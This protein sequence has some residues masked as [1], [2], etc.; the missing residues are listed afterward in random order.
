MDELLLEILTKVT[1]CSFHSPYSAKMVCK[2]FNQLAQHDRI[3]EHINIRRFERVNP[4]TSWSID[5][6]I[7]KFLER[8]REWNNLNALYNQG[9]QWYFRYDN[10][11]LGIESLKMMITKGHQASS[12]VILVLHRGMKKR[13]A[14]I[15]CIL[16]TVRNCTVLPSKQATTVEVYKVH[17]QSDPIGITSAMT[18]SIVAIRAN[19]IRK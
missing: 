8:C 15:L 6:E 7:Y 9:M 4:L 19:G 5:E 3:F 1:S 18:N 10:F 16:S 17:L 14:S 11:E 13:K 12:Y 2:K